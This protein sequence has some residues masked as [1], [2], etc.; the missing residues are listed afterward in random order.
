MF[1]ASAQQCKTHGTRCLDCHELIDACTCP[2]LPICPRQCLTIDSAIVLAAFDSANEVTCRFSQTHSQDSE[3]AIEVSS[4]D[5]IL[6]GS[7]A[8]GHNARRKEEVARQ[9]ASLVLRR[10]KTYKRA[11]KAQE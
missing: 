10:G 5:T 7:D 2:G 8:G 1:L 6:E 11:S 9:P 3:E 4:K